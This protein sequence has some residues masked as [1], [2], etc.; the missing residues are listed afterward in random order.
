MDGV[1]AQ[2]SLE[3]KCAYV[4]LSKDITDEELAKVVTDAGYE[5]KEIK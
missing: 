1:E 5:V 2:V 3:G 4:T